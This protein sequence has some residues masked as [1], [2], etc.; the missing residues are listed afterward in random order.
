LVD[1]ESDEPVSKPARGWLGYQDFDN[2]VPV[3]PGF[4]MQTAS[5]P[6]ALAGFATGSCSKLDN[7]HFGEPELA[8][9]SWLD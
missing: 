4:A 8:D 9:S 3:R 1:R 2:P 6:I 5:H 7:R